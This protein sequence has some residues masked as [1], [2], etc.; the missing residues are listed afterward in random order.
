MKAVFN[1][2]SVNLRPV[3]DTR[4]T[5]TDSDMTKG[6]IAPHLVRFTIPMIAGNICQLMYNATDAAIVGRFLGKEP[7]AAVG[8][9]TPVV[10]I[11]TFLIIGICLGASILMSEFY[12]AKKWN[13]LRSELATTF[14][15]GLVFTCAIIVS[16]IMLAVPLMTLLRVPRDIMTDAV[17][18]LRIQ[19][20]GLIFTFMYNVYASALRS[21]G[22]SKV[23]L[24]F[25]IVSASLNIIMDTLFIL[26]F[27]W[28][29]AGV[30]WAT[31][32]AE[33]LSALLCLGYVRLSIPVLRIPWRE[34]RIR[35]SLLHYTISYSCVTAMQQSCNNIGKMLIQ[36]AVNPLGVTA[37][38][39]FSAA[40]R[41]DDFMMI[42]Q[43]N[44]GHAAST[45]LAQNRGAGHTER[46]RRGFL[47]AVRMEMV[48]SI[49]LSLFIACIVPSLLRL[50]IG[51]DEK[52]V[53]AVG[54]GYLYW[55]VF[56]YFIPGLTN[57]IQGYFRGM[58]KMKI[59]LW[60]TI[61]QIGG[62]VIFVFILTPFWG[63]PG[64]AIASL[65]GWCSMFLY[66]LPL[67]RRSWKRLTSCAGTT[68]KTGS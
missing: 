42:P 26:V 33:A 67:F 63:I 23:P 17:L 68:G 2:L 51:H 7:F 27:K 14:L 28:G 3:K 20:I 65:L 41:I 30:A 45:F 21:M 57:V 37:I 34:F 35:R 54:A 60:S 1:F 56:F 59:T 43:Q 62:R 15:A 48:Y 52:E 53:V 46:M 58:G 11:I 66:E 40:S 49:L 55:M 10:N 38:A 8:A 44:I 31:V 32:T 25:L 39:A 64:I 19:F 9:S 47:T 16:G 13:T 50:F 5:H 61:F 29:I 6:A 12:G 36:G 22:D 24:C 4:M 18:Y